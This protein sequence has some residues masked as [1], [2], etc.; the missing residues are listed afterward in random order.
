MQTEY[1]YPA[2]A[3]RSSPKEWEEREKPDLIKEAI[4]RKNNILDKRSGIPLINPIIDRK[5]RER[6]KIVI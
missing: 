1:I 4:K 6:F 5:I 3:D 2:V